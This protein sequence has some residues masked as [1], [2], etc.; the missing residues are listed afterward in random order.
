L[1]NDVRSGVSVAFAVSAMVC[2][3]SCSLQPVTLCQAQCDR[4]VSLCGLGGLGGLDGL[5]HAFGGGGH[6]DVLHTEVAD[7]ID[8]G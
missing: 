7:G 6:V 3:F 4:P 5:P 8:N 1:L 2:S